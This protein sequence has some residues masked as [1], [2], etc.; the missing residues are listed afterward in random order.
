MVVATAALQRQHAARARPRPPRR[1]DRH[2]RG[3]R[4]SPKRVWQLA[5]HEPL[6]ALTQPSVVDVIAAIQQTRV[7][8]GRARRGDDR[9][10][11]HLVALLDVLYRLAHGEKRH[12]R[13][14]SARFATTYDQLATALHQRFGIFPP[15]PDEERDPEARAEWLRKLRPLLYDWLELARRARLITNDSR[16]VKD[17]AGVWWR[18]EI[19]VLGT[20]EL[21]AE[22]LDAAERRWA[23]FPDR[24]RDRQRRG[25]QTPYAQ[26]YRIA[27][28]PSKAQKKRLAV[29]RAKATYRARRAHGNGN[30]GGPFGPTVVPAEPHVEMEERS[31][32]E[33]LADTDTPTNRTSVRGRKRP[34]N[35][36]RLRRRHPADQL[37][38]PQRPGGGNLDASVQPLTEGGRA[39]LGHLREFSDGLDAL[40]ERR[41]G[42]WLAESAMWVE[43]GL[44]MAQ[45]VREP[46]R[47]DA[48][49]R[50]ELIEAILRSWYLERYGADD[51]MQRLPWCP[52]PPANDAKRNV[53]AMFDAFDLYARHAA[54][55]LPGWPS[56]PVLALLRM[57]STPLPPYQ[58]YER[59]PDGSWRSRTVKPGLPDTIGYAI[60]GL[61]ML[62]RDMAAANTLLQ[63]RRP[64]ISRPEL[65]QPPAPSR[66]GHKRPDV[67]DEHDTLTR[68][69]RI[70]DQLVAAGGNPRQHDTVDSMELELIDRERHGLLPLDFGYPSPIAMRAHAGR[71]MPDW[72]SPTPEP[73][74]PADAWA[75][76]TDAARQW[77]DLDTIELWL[78][79]M[80]A[81]EHADGT[82]TIGAE[83][84][85]LSFV[86]DRLGRLLDEIREATGAARRLQL[87]DLADPTRGRPDTPPK[88]YGDPGADGQTSRAKR[89]LRRHEQERRRLLAECDHTL[90]ATELVA[91]RASD[92]DHNRRWDELLDIADTRR[93]FHSRTVVT[94]FLRPLLPHFGHDGI[95]TLT[96]PSDR[97]EPIRK[98]LGDQVTL[99]VRTLAGGKAVRWQAIDDPTLR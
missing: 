87:V 29:A 98:H 79:P 52:R 45:I 68:R 23:A 64:H 91:R 97:L 8:D 33:T 71:W 78:E 9:L 10:E 76:I 26:I 75:Q 5:G 63:A 13:A 24:E 32:E 3:H 40:W 70:R 99:L 57:A 17:N 34:G 19:T 48:L 51:M 28:A 61:R 67:W 36:P 83:T 92:T 1:R 93:E 7:A 41:Y 84:R 43:D 72:H 16:G 60:A 31:L 90:T 53:A 82:L 47:R 50:G 11:A 49:S 69:D 59:Q 38:A 14:G 20:P 66:F 88:T 46:A 62:A 44:R 27:K 35:A 80:T 37:P 96:G 6:E 22:A 18:T 85:H 25:R 12:G 89:H 65:Y 39:D 81:L 77:L 94:L 86:R 42:R 56:D 54:A 21:P 73:V 55:A 74:S 30:S 15:P 2:R 58:R 95:L 4:F